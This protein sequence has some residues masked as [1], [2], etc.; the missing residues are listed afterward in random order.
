MTGRTKGGYRPGD[1]DLWDRVAETVTHRNPRRGDHIDPVGADDATNDPHPKPKSARSRKPAPGATV[2]PLR[3]SPKPQPLPDLVHGKQ[4]GLDRRTETRLRRGQV[5]V[6]G[7]LDLHG[8]T[9]DQAHRALQSFITH[10]YHGEKRCVLVITG[11]GLS[12]DG[13]IGVLRSMTPRWLNEPGLREM[14]IGFRQSARQHGGEGALYV[15]LKR[16]RSG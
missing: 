7:R 9:Q 8:M 4:P 15:L 3:Q 11:K 13:S 2:P 14:V 6:E 10:A 16:R 1:A 12:A 5:P